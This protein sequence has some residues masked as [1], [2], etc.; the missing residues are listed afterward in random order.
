MSLVKEISKRRTFAII[1]HPDAGKTTL[2]EKMLLYGKAIHLAGSV[3][4][5]RNQRSTR[6]DW[7]SIE[8]ERGISI[9]S[10]V[11]QFPYNGHV[12]NLLDT[13]GHADFS[14][15]TYR[16][17]SAVDSAVMVLDAAKGIEAQ[18]K[19]L[20]EVCRD[21]GIPIFTFI[22]K[23]DRPSKDPLELLDELETV[24]RMEPV[25][26][27]WP[28]GSGPSF[29][30]V[31]DLA[32]Q[33]VHL[34]DRT[35]RNQTISPELIT[36]IEDERIRSTLSDYELENLDGQLEL[37]EG[38]GLDFDPAKVLN[39][40]QTPVFFGS[41]LTNFGVE[42]FMNAFVEV[43]PPPASYET[44]GG[45]INPSDDVF[46]GF[47]FK[48]QANMDPKHRDSVAYMRICSGK[49]E[50][51]MTVKHPQSGKNLRLPSPYTFFADERHVVE[52]AYPGD[53]IGLPNKD[54]AIGDTL[55]SGKNIKFD[56]IPRFDPEHF[57]MLRN[58]DISKQK[59]FLKGLRQLE[60][61]GAM[62]VLY[63]ADSIQRTPILAVVGQ[64]QFDVVIAR[65]KAEYNVDTVLEAQPWQISR[66]VEGTDADIDA[67]PWGYGVVKATDR[68]N[69][70]VAL[71]RSKYDLEHCQQ[72]YPDVTFEV[73]H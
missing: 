6:S 5:R 29:M 28:I 14:E 34:F 36:T 42:L 20:F 48:I 60:K 73:I 33:D 17:L 19:K 16:T 23:M 39:G 71:F 68:D 26:V 49:F 11:M 70:L 21:R 45:L 64:L 41:A 69:K 25:P 47:V 3:R 15:D 58:T 27:N 54:F 44:E 13:P 51:N 8:K 7:M 65:L 24:L 43:A 30:G 22:N 32:S 57:A 18:T 52:D 46:S 2:T 12:V 61:E 63:R 31:Y 38:L 37:I 59:N 50:R 56:A 1:S 67:L 53:I 35:S 72:K 66:W 55:H 9:S 10:T 62:Q 40:Q 4:A